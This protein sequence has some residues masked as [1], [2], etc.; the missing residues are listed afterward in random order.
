MVG[1]KQIRWAISEDAITGFRVKELVI[2]MVGYIAG[3]TSH[4]YRGRPEEVCE[5][6]LLTGANQI[7]DKLNTCAISKKEFL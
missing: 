1:P 4:M 3:E 2:F 5:M 6:A 7:I